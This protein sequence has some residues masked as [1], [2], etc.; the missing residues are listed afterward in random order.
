MKRFMV[1]MILCGMALLIAGCAVP[2]GEDYSITRDGA[3]LAYI[4]D[5]NLQ[6]YVPIPAAGQRPVIQVANRDD[7]DITVAWKDENGIEIAL[8]FETFAANMVYQA[9]IKITPKPGYGFYSTPF[10][11][12][13]GKTS[14]QIDD[15]GDP[16][17]TV[18]VTYNNSNDW[19][20]TFITDYNLQNYVPIPLDGERP[21]RAIKTRTDIQVE[22]IWR[23]FNSGDYFVIDSDDPTPFYFDQGVVYQAEIKLT[24]NPGYRFIQGRYFAYPDGT[25][26]VPQGDQTDPRVRSFIV[27]YPPTMSPMVVNDLNLTPYIPKPTGGGTPVISFAGIQYTGIVSWKNTNTQETLTGPFQPGTAYTAELDLNPGVGYTFTGAGVFI[28]TGA[29]TISPRGSGSVTITFPPSAGA[30]NP[31]IVYDTILTSRLPRPVNGITPIT[32]ITSSQYS[33][34]VAWTPADSS[35]QLT[36]SYKAVITLTAAPGFTF[37]GIGQNVFSHDDAPGGVTNSQNSG[38]VTIV[39]PAARPPSY[40]AVTFGGPG[41]E[42][43]ALMIMRERSID[44][45]QVRIDLSPGSESV[46]Y[47][48]ILLAGNTSPADVVLDGSG[49]VLTKTSPGSYITVAGGVTLT[50]Q[51]I[52]L[53]GLTNNNAPLITVLSGGKLLLGA[54]VVLAG[55]DTISD[56]GGIWVDG[57][58]LVIN[59]GAVIKS[60][61][62]RRAGGVLVNNSGRVIMGGGTIGGT[63]LANGNKVSGQIYSGGGVFVDNGFFDMYGGTIQYNEADSEHC[64]GGVAIVGRGNFGFNQH[65]G[66]IKNNVAK[67]PHSGGGV[68][69]YKTNPD[70]AMDSTFIMAAA[71]VVEGNI[72]KAAHSGGGVY[73][74]QDGFRME[75]GTIRGNFAEQPNSGGGIYGINRF[76]IHGGTIQGNIA[77]APNSGGGIYGENDIDDGTWYIIGGGTIKE[78][79]AEQPNSGGGIALIGD[80]SNGVM[81]NV[82]DMTIKSNRALAE[83]SGGGLYLFRTDIE[84]NK[85]TI[86]DNI[87]A[88]RRSG[89]AVYFSRGSVHMETTDDGWGWDI[90]GNKATWNT[91]GAGNESAGAVY[92]IGDIDEEAEFDMK[93]G[94][95]GGTNPGDANTASIGANGVYIA[96]YGRLSMSGGEITGNTGGDNY[97]VYIASTEEGAFIIG[98]EGKVAMNNMVFLAP[99]VVLSVEGGFQGIGP[100]ANITCD[101]PVAYDTNPSTATKLLVARDYNNNAKDIIDAVKGRFRF[102]GA[103]IPIKTS[104]TGEADPDAVNVY[105]YYGYYNKVL[106]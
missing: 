50:L 67:Q 71:A 32:G 10:A 22:V 87:A 91:P 31:T 85:G 79:I 37:T 41:E 55:N 61:R 70:F 99:G 59:N 48:V 36:V 78:N 40:P 45:S 53:N 25:T 97:G 96:E 102:R 64:A 69:A 95:I 73:S 54:G 30:G 94:T 103:S 3:G 6:T 44:N 20:I 28:H 42:N 104:E 35:F 4:T 38:T 80:I 106:P 98:D 1:L 17:R 76:S 101:S 105:Y 13:A 5:Y 12:P 58:T 21:V 88:G 66:T 2:L 29:E 15:L 60:M 77:K 93:F 11:Y 65:G 92:I 63:E 46:G 90:K 86:E 34:T 82:T 47:S 39:F 89:G 49:R 81:I 100:V 18:T 74:R 7:L 9:E 51:N 33:G 27:T 72:A 83:N 24:A 16:T 26:A 23:E 68:Y 84:M 62:A 75:A 52:T 57:G 43:S 56:A 8:P 14:A 19:D